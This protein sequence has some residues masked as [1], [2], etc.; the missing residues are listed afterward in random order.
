[1]G[2][3]IL[4]VEDNPTNRDL[5]TYLLTAFGHDVSAT[6]SGEAALNFLSRKRPDLIICDLDLP[7][8]SGYEVV[9]QLK[10]DRV[11]SAITIVAVTAMA[12]VGERAKVLAAGFD[13]YLSKP[14]DPETFSQQLDRFMPA[15]L[16]STPPAAITQ[17]DGARPASRPAAAVTLLILDSLGQNGAIIRGLLAGMGFHLLSASD[18]QGALKLARSELPDLIVSD[19]PIAPMVGCDL[20]RAA[21]ADVAL[22]RTPFIYLTASTA[23]SMSDAAAAALGVTRVSRALPPN[24]LRKQILACLPAPIRPIDPAPLKV[25]LGQ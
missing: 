11:L 15:E 22:L 5:I 3:H 25:G 6:A 9:R 8:I 20:L 17:S 23:D 7:G 19:A 2:A 18:V 10:L 21:R 12:M 13:G 1:M 24:A 14:I 4:L 16:R